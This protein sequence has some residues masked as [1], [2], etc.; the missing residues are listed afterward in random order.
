[1][2]A[3]SLVPCLHADETIASFASRTAALHE[4]P[5][6][7]TFASLLGFDFVGLCRG[8]TDDVKKFAKIIGRE[9]AEL[10]ASLTVFDFRWSITVRG[11]ALSK[12]FVAW[13]Q[14]RVCPGC[15]NDDEETLPGRAGT[16]AYSR[17]VWL[18]RF[19]RACPVHG[20]K[21]VETGV[22][23]WQMGADFSARLRTGRRSFD[24]LQRA[25]HELA[26]TDHER[27]LV[28]RF[29]GGRPSGHWLDRFPL[30][31]AAHLPRLV[32]FAQNP[33]SFLSADPSAPER[34][35]VASEG[36]AILAGGEDAFRDVVLSLI[37]A[38]YRPREEFCAKTILGNL[39]TEL[40]D[41]QDHPGYADALSLIRETAADVVPVG[42]SDDFLGTSLPRR[43]HSLHT[44][45]REF[46]LP[47]TPLRKAVEESGL[48]ATGDFC[49]VVFPAA[50]L[51]EIAEN[52][53]GKTPRLESEIAAHRQFLAEAESGWET[54]TYQP[55]DFITLERAY[56]RLKVTP[57][58]V[59]ALIDDGYLYQARVPTKH[60]SF[61]IRARDVA[62]FQKIYISESELRHSKKF[63][64][65]FEAKIKELGLKPAIPSD[66]V[67]T[68][69]FRID[70]I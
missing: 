4:F 58:V 32:G 59:E 38:N 57:S 25:S 62:E 33:R 10:Q 24:E 48:A 41:L 43:M 23:N 36:F 68:N 12:E 49:G 44:A 18:P 61:R 65:D 53:P 7:R 26:A 40:L 34:A 39:S 19:V 54:S 29:Q 28:D 35:K 15:I 47:Y 67:G 70:Q 46:G 17:L 45:A 66:S 1:M 63:R 8:Q 52:L 22:W 16:R 6:A 27:Y 64:N 30:Q 3:M 56:I 11:H 21:L 37:K 14:N 69:F 51:A 55:K 42:P 20:R 60:R 13:N 50:S 2:N 5:D 31:L 9:T